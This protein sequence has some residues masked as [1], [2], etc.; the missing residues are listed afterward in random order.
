VAALGLVD[1]HHAFDALGLEALFGDD[2]D[3]RRPLVALAGATRVVS[4]FG[5]RDAGFTARLRA[6]AADVAVAPSVPPDDTLVW[7]HLF[8]TVD[9]DGPAD[10][11]PVTV[12]TAVH[13]AGRTALAGAGWTGGPLAIVH[14]GAGGMTKRWPAAG[15]ARVVEL[16]QGRADM[17]VLLHEGPTDAEAVAAVQAALARR[18]EV[19]RQPALPE[20]AGALRHVSAYVGNDSGVSHLAAAVGAPTLALFAAANVRWQS[21]SPAARMRVVGTAAVGPRDVA[22]VL[23]DLGELLG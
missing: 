8:A 1:V 21:W 13:D 23:A 2:P 7:A 4:W 15:F 22:A 5:S 19:L 18:C 12:P 3:D 10:R 6:Q 14:P 16:L 11:A 9:A 20:L 17:Q